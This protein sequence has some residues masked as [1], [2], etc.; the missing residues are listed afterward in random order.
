MTLRRS[1]FKLILVCQITAF[2]KGLAVAKPFFPQ[3][4][5]IY[6]YYEDY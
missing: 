6:E 1:S 4:N 2:Q 5:A 3:V